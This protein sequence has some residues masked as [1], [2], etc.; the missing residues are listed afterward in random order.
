MQS[1]IESYGLPYEDFRSLLTTT[2]SLVAGSSAL[3]M[4]LQQNGVDPGFVPGDLDIWAEDTNDMIDSHGVF[5]Q[6]S[7]N[8]QFT[9]FLIRNGY[10]LTDKFEEK[11][12]E[13]EPLHQIRHILSFVNREGK[14]VQLI[15]VRQ[16]DLITYIKS[17]FDL[18]PCV[19]WWNAAEDTFE[20]MFASLTLQKKMYV[21]PSREVDVREVE[22][23]AKY[24]SR[25]FSLTEYPCAARTVADPLENVESLED[26]TA[27]D[28]FAYE[29]V[30]AAAFLRA[31]SYHML[32]RVGE[33]FHAFHRNTLYD[34]LHAHMFRMDSLG[35]VVT[36]PHKQTV[37][38]AFSRII[39]Y[40]DYT[41]FHLLHN[42]EL[43]GKS[44][45]T[46]KCFTT[47]QWLQ[48][49]PGAIM[50]PPLQA[51]QEAL[52]YFSVALPLYHPDVYWMD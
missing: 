8:V 33:Q 22:R 43:G 17:Y 45:Y 34:Y 31:S 32:I 4:Y 23:I 14:Q 41:I 11:Q 26:T 10:N 51:S 42:Y 21:H 44:I 47:A 37:L 40:S 52:D 35:D 20:T 9:L 7:H 3:A 25:G 18:S 19:T 38:A 28:V 46:V 24:E 16:P 12:D 48:G 2:N 39:P 49:E 50:E 15:L 13:Y 6:R 5:R 36:L 30:N 29:D 27:F 1:F